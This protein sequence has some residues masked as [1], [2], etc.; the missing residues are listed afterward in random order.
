[1]STLTS[2]I[3]PDGVLIIKAFANA[4]E[5]S[6]KRAEEFAVLPTDETEDKFKVTLDVSEYKPSEITIHVN[7]SCLIV[8]AERKE[9]KMDEH[10]ALA[11]HKRYE[12]KFSLTP[13][14]DSESLSS[15][16]R[17]GNITI[18]APKKK[19]EKQ[20]R[21]LEIKEDME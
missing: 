21:T 10:G 16:Y 17:D 14:V 19:L 11:H 12:R 18:E 13:E 6:G 9:E 20:M 15:R 1:M 8:T 5:A 7:E 3:T 4:K 2:T